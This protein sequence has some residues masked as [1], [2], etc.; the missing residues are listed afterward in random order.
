MASPELSLVERRSRLS[1]LDASLAPAVLAGD[2]LLPVLPALEPLLPRAGLARGTVMS[3][4]GSG[5]ALSLA[6][7]ACAA[8]S[9]EGSWVAAL[10]T[11]RLGLA[12]VRELGVDLDRLVVVTSSGSP[13]WAAVAAA[14]VDAFDLVLMVT[15]RQVPATAARRLAARAR[16]RGSVII[17][18]GRWGW[19]EA[20]DV[21]LDVVECHW[22]GL[23]QGHGLL[24]AR[25]VTV[26]AVNRR[27]AQ[28]RRRAALWLPDADGR[29]RAAGHDSRSDA[30][31]RW[32]GAAA[33]HDSR[34]DTGGRWSGADADELVAVEVARV[35]NPADSANDA[36]SG[37]AKLTVAGSGSTSGNDSSGH[38]DDT[39][40]D[41][42]W[43]DAG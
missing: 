39:N 20:P 9:A 33:G 35:A 1:A 7:A 10:D 6:V 14:L 42:H 25:R 38:G 22:D 28:P 18:V 43:A 37:T 23:D 4:S 19:P 3:V 5:G 21:R 36:N 40:A 12:A 27:D 15:R 32:S 13:R 11:D 29:V 8:A 24:Q 41:D 2:Q 16:E 30:G 31:G 34:S 17:Q 26:T